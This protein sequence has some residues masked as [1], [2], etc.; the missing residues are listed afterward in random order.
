VEFGRVVNKI[1]IVPDGEGHFVAYAIGSDVYM[2]APPL[3]LPAAQADASPIK[4]DK[5]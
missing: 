1:R 2:F 3:D 5:P 4:V